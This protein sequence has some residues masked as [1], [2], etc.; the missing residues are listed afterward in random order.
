M[1]D[2]RWV[3]HPDLQMPL[4]DQRA[5][6][7]MMKITKFFKPDAICNIGDL[8]NQDGPSRWADGSADEVLNHLEPENKMVQNYWKDLRAKYPRADLHW[9]LGNHDIRAFDYINKKAPALRDLVTPDVL[10]HTDKY[11]VNLY[12]WNSPPQLKMGDIYLHHGSAVSKHSG[13]S[14][15]SD[16]DSWGVSLIRGHSH[17][18]GTYFKTY[19]LT[20]QMLRGYEIG[21]GMDISKATYAQCHNWQQGMAIGIESDGVS[22]IQLI[23][24]QNYSCYIGTKRF[25]A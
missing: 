16:I 2:K 25:E 12:D 6:D 3:I 14:V 22:H 24:F 13:G 7:L 5:L 8:A 20:G 21:H 18:V 23:P 19:E 1:T 10:W 11:G 17:R 9:T 4:H 15:Q